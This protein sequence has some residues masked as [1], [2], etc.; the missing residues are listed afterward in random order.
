MLSNSVLEEIMNIPSVLILSVLYTVLGVYKP[1]YIFY[2]DFIKF[3]DFY[4]ALP[5]IP[6]D[7]SCRQGNLS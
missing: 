5:C 1:L 7:V 6:L 4:K 2:K 3:C